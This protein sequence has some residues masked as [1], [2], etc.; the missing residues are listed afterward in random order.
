M[1]CLEGRTVIRI[2]SFK[3]CGKEK[4]AM[5]EYTNTALENFKKFYDIQKFELLHLFSLRNSEVPFYFS[6]ESSQPR[7]IPIFFF[8]FYLVYQP[9]LIINFVL[10]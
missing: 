7:F 3:K 6:F 9:Y 8:F 2:N 4:T 1:C 10:T 5:R